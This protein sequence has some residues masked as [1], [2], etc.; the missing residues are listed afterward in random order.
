VLSG[1]VML[2]AAMP[3]VDHLQ[4]CKVA[5]TSCLKC[6]LSVPR[7]ALQQHNNTGFKR[8]SIFRG[9]TLR[10]KKGLGHN[11]LYSKAAKAGNCGVVHLGCTSA[12]RNVCTNKGKAA[13]VY[14][15]VTALI[16]P[17]CAGRRLCSAH[18]LTQPGQHVCVTSS[19]SCSTH[20][21][22]PA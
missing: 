13:C 5:C 16:P 3:P 17:N 18:L 4:C 21:R 22:A 11:M 6:G 10:C 8:L 9:P 7:E 20:G 2:F 19:S 1:I 15:T 14:R 12:C